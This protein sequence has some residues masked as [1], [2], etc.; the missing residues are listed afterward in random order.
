[1]LLPHQK[2]KNSPLEKRSE[3]NVFLYEYT[4]VYIIQVIKFVK[5]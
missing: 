4:E 2:Q 1:M 3:E 5:A